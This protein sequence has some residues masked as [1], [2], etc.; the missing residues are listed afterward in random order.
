MRIVGDGVL[1]VPFHGF[2]QST[3]DSVGRGFTPAAMIAKIHGGTKAPPY[4]I[5][6]GF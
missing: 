5:I 1:D 2:V 3:D 4:S 6:C